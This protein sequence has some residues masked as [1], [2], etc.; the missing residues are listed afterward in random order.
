MVNGA[1][2]LI[3]V[4]DLTYLGDYVP[5]FAAPAGPM[6]YNTYDEYLAMMDTGFR[7]WP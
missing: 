1:N 6:P 3:A 4:E 5:D 7:R 2:R